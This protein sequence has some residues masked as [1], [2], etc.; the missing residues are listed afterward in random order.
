MMWCTLT[1][2]DGLIDITADVTRWIVFSSTLN[3]RFLRFLQALYKG[4]MC[5]LKVNG[6]ISD[7]VSTG[8]RQECVLSSCSSPYTSMAL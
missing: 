5:R 6:Q 2:I 8:L 1:M 7:E 4:S 3:S